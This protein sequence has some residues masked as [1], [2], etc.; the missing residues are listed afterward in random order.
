MRVAH[1]DAAHVQ[2]LNDE[3]STLDSERQKLEDSVEENKNKSRH[4]EE[5]IQYSIL[6]T[7]VG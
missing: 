2:V 7:I 3:V 1:G 4:A 5:Q 6:V